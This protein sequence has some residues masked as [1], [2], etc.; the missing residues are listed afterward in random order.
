[1]AL[2][3]CV[4][5]CTLSCVAAIS[6][7]PHSDDALRNKEL[8]GH[9]VLAV[10]GKQ[11]DGRSP[12]CTVIFEDRNG[13]YWA[14]TYW[15]LKRYDERSDRWDD[16][17]R[18]PWSVDS[19]CQSADG[20][21]WFA[22]RLLRNQ[23]TPSLVSFD[24]SEWRN[25]G[26]LPKA[27]NDVRPGAA[28]VMFPARGGSLWFARGDELL[29]Y[30]ARGWGDP[31]K[32]SEAIRSEFPVNIRAGL[33]DSEGNI[34]LAV[35][36]GIL[37]FDE[38]KRQWATLDPFA[39]KGSVPP[40]PKRPNYAELQIVDGV[41][42]IYQD[43]KGKVWFASSVP[44]SYLSYDKQTGFWA[45]YRLAD[46]LPASGPKDVDPGLTKMYQDRFGRM[47]FGTNLGLITFN[48]H[49]KEWQIL[50]TENSVLPNNLITTIFEDRSGRIWIGTGEG[51]V[52][53]E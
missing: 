39:Q 41:Y 43:R 53:L 8:A 47:M 32:V 9:R 30:D 19:I 38:L 27:K 11:R 23:N 25:I 46:F 37:R 5:A 22:R 42:D 1:M 6:A 7:L 13:V 28:T 20:K 12:A 24:G 21:L 52:V 51:I 17:T 33:Q 34:W 4:V 48:E 50:T 45:H 10:W 44:G 14:G 2:I 40:E 3:K 18:A 29:A 16:E 49:D 36:G 26:S 35:S 31:L 15:G